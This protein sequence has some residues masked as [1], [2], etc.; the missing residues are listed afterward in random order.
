MDIKRCGSTPSRRP[1]ADWFTGDVWQDPIVQ[2]EAPGRVH[3]VMVRFDPAARTNW[4]TH[5]LGQTLHVVS[6][7]GLVQAEGEPIQEINAGD[8]VWIPAGQRHW[9]GAK[10][11]VGMTHIAI[12]EA[13]D[14]KAAEWQ[15][16]VSDADYGA[17]PVGS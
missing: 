17:W 6:G 10:P 15:E 14:G 11:D 5:P 2:A 7:S 9:H 13:L 4:H 1:N 16:P 12:Q 3:S 8:S